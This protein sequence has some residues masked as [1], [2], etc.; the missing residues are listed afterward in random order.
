M[1]SINS[2]LAFLLL[3]ASSL[4]HIFTCLKT[5]TSMKKLANLISYLFHPL[6]MLSYLTAYF[7]YTNNYFAYFVSPVKKLFLMAAVV[8]FSV[9]LPLLNMVLLKKKGYIK[10]MKARQS[11]QR[12]F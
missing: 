12:F 7:L 8:I 11:S 3:V 2:T 6:F 1:S 4:L 10:N 9:V 5:N